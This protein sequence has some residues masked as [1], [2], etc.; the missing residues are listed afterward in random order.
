MELVLARNAHQTFQ[1]GRCRLFHPTWMYCRLENVTS[2]PLFL[3]GPRHPSAASALPT[4]LFL[5][6]PGEKTP[7][8]WDCKGLLIPS[9][10]L[11][12][13]GKTYVAGPAALKY[14][15]MRRVQI[16]MENAVYRCPRSNGLLPLGHVDSVTS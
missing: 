12:L 4:S 16:R 6:P 15:D 10:R 7:K 1:E 14:R 5:L 13:N 2:E 9:D 3:Y 8:C 11:T